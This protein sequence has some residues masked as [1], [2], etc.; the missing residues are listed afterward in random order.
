[1]SSIDP[2]L[3]LAANLC[4]VN[5]GEV[6]SFSRLDDGGLRVDLQSGRVEFI[7]ADVVRERHPDRPLA[8]AS[9]AESEEAED[10]PEV[11]VKTRKPR[12]KAGS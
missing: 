8:P 12:K 7:A 11:M 5:I 2:W 4:S 3:V 1:M 9:G 6:R 10:K